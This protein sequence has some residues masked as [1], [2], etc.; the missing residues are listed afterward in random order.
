MFG[1]QPRGGRG[2]SACPRQACFVLSTQGPSWPSQYFS[3]LPGR[4]AKG[5]SYWKM[6][7][8]WE[9]HWAL[10]RQSRR[11]AWRRCEGI[12]QRPG[13]SGSSKLKICIPSILL[14][15]F[16]PNWTQRTKA[17]VTSQFITL[18]F[19]GGGV[20]GGWGGVGGNRQQRKLLN[21]S[22]MSR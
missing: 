15:E 1:R 4:V 22:C 11:A 17:S 10:K 21:Y 6:P 5:G 20:A 18:L 8:P 7:G 14:L 3:G 19:P 16:D 9:R 2:L 12:T 13:G